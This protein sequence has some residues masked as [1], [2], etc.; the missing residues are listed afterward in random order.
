MLAILDAYRAGL[1]KPKNWPRNIVAG[2]MVGIVALP[3]SMALAIACGVQP[4]QGL[5]TSIIAGIVVAIF[6]GSR[7]QI[8]GPSGAFIIILASITEQYGVGGLQV[9]TLLAG[10]MLLFMGWLK[11]GSIIKFIPDPV[12]IGFTAGI[13]VIIFVGEWKNFFGLNVHLPLTAH[14]HE[15]LWLLIKALPTLSVPTTGLALLSLAFIFITP[16]IV[17]VIPG[18]LVALIV[19]TGLQLFFH[20]KG[21]AT[22]SSTFGAIPKGLP[23]FKWPHMNVD[24]ILDLIFPAFTIALLGAIESLLS[25]T[26]AD[27]L[28]DTRHHSNQEL[29]GQGI[30]N[31]IVPLFG[32]FAATGVIARTAVNARLGGN[33]P[34]AAI[35]HSLLLLCIVL[36]LAPLI[37]DIPLCALAAVLFAVSYTMSDLPRFF[38]MMYRASRYDAAIL[39][40]T[41]FLTVFINLIVAVNIGVILAMMFFVRHMHEV[42]EVK[43]QEHSSLQAE[44]QMAGLATFPVDT[45]VYTIQGPFF[46]GA[47]EKIE[48]A[49]GVSH[50]DAHYMI[51]RL[52][53][54]PF[55]D[56]TGLKTF[57]AL[58]RR[59]SAR[60]V[61][62]YLCEANVRVTKW[63]ESAEILALAK[64]QRVFKHLADALIDISLHANLNEKFIAKN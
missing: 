4:E 22:L 51:F 58:L 50:Q 55:M 9:A 45:L 60:G 28:T 7:I 48:Q 49:L 1:L 47:A 23:P 25:A 54:V 10:V 53:E 13:G 38:G 57:H 39:I 59:F 24:R 19:A 6:G 27:G 32:G 16:K 62:V 14:F 41:F 33:S 5:Y 64:D 31:I 42:V 2:L 46:F 40:L 43:R 18:T 30:S 29:K 8:A 36:L 3:L 15:K 63:L 44:L 11:L 21:V 61:V 35:V 20:F 34:I 37:S 56:S 26:A 17:K 12:I 52:A